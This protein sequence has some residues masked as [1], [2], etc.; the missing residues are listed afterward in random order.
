MVVEDE[1]MRGT[2]TGLRAPAALAFLLITAVLLIFLRTIADLLAT[3]AGLLLS[4]ICVIGAEGWL[5]PKALGLIGPPNPLTSMVPII[6]ISLT[7]DYAIQTVS[8]YR[9]QRVS[10]VPSEV[11][12]RT[13]LR[14]V[15][16]PL[17]LAAATTIVSLLASLFSPIE[18]V[19]DFGVVAG[20]GVGL[21][22]IVMLTLLPAIRAII[23][24]RREAQG[25]LLP[26][27]PIAHFLPGIGRAWELLGVEVTR[28]PSLYFIAVLVVTAGLGFAATG[29]RSEFSIRDILP[30]GGS[31]LADMETLDATV[32]GSTEMVTVLVKAE[33]TEARTLLNLRDLADAFGDERLRPRAAAGPLLASYEMLLRDWIHDSEA[34]GDRYDPELETL[35]RNASAGVGLD[36]TLMQ[37][38]LDKLGARDP[39]LARL[40]VNSPEGIDSILVQFP[41]YTNDPEA[42]KALQSEIEALWYGEDDEI[43]AIS[44]EVISIEVTNIITSRQTESISTTVAVALVILIIFFWVAWRQ[45]V[46]GFIAVGPIV[47]VLISVLGT[48]ALAGIPY[49]VVTSIITVLSIGIGVDYTI[50]VIHRYRE[51]F[52]HLRSPEKAAAI[53]LATTGPALLGSAM[54]TALGIGVLA[55]GPLEASQQFG[56]TAAITIAYSLLASILLVI[57]SMTIWGAYQ[58]MR[59]R[60]MVERWSDELDEAIDAI[61]R[62]H[63][64]R[65]P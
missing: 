35:F 59:L 63:E 16:L 49:T 18:L 32:G 54:T 3:I 43:T 24:R 13:G 28:R 7:V 53:T 50:H 12:V 55:V 62:H 4:L 27:R 20:T 36:M 58:N 48:M 17:T 61:H 44:V 5:G 29:L 39:A 56:I 31:V 19:G 40:L 9:E 6:V 33:A 51:E 30:R 2:E 38:F 64:Q 45:P 23:D 47:L 65:A 10:C 37:E 21:S 22:L 42:T 25:T 11:A 52:F 15:A 14:R 41:A 34:P 26:A 57:P 8:Y 46:L 60:S 1:Y